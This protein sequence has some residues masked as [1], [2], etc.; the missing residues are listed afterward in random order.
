MNRRRLIPLSIAGAALVVFVL[1]GFS[2]FRQIDRYNTEQPPQIFYTFV[3]NVPAFEFAGRRVGISGDNIREDGTGE[4][5]VTYGDET[6]SLP[7]TIPARVTLPRL[8]RYRDWLVFVLWRENEGFDP[9]ETRRFMDAGLIEGNLVAVRKVPRPGA[10]PESFGE[11][12]R[13]DWSFDFFTFDPEG[14]FDHERLVFPESER[15]FQRRIQRAERDGAPRPERRR[16]ELQ[17]STWQY[18]SA[19]HL[20]GGKPP[21]AEFTRGQLV[22]ARLPLALAGGSCLVFLI[23]LGFGLAPRRSDQWPGKGDKKNA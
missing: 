17:P 3:L 19:M 10:D 8:E 12:F 13:S 7:V 20:M 23:A 15:A 21:S 1:S 22:E 11:V 2:L 6:L 9:E 4:V 14:G 5:V 18:A 16:N